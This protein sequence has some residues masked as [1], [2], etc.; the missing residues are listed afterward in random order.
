MVVPAI[1]EKE[2][3]GER[4]LEERLGDCSATDL[5]GKTDPGWA[6]KGKGMGKEGAVTTTTKLVWDGTKGG[7]EGGIGDA[8][9]RPTAGTNRLHFQ[10]NHYGKPCSSRE[11][12]GKGVVV[13]SEG[14]PQ[15]GRSQG[16]RP[17]TAAPQPQ[18]DNPEEDEELG[19]GVPQG[20]G[21]CVGWK[22]EELPGRR[23]AKLGV[24][25]AATVLTRDDRAGLCISKKATKSDIAGP[26]CQEAGFNTRNAA[27]G[28]AIARREK[29][30]GKE[31]RAFYI[32]GSRE[33]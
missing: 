33:V 26:T 30:K 27:S 18:A 29:V 12:A 9:G 5:G 19:G 14:D 16:R 3:D 24:K 6:V 23:L 2:G 13:E 4:Q 15:G 1:V 28:E 22:E 25:A 31:S 20:W 32:G 8:A 21:I 17:E 11:V 7:E 10:I